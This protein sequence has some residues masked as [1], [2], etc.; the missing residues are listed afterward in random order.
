MHNESN[1]GRG[2]HAVTHDDRQRRRRA[3]AAFIER[4]WHTLLLGPKRLPLRNCDQCRQHNHDEP[5]PRYV[6]HSG[7]ID[8]PHPLGTCH[9]YQAA[10]L[11]LDHVLGLLDRHPEANLG[12]ATEP[13]G[14]VVVDVD[15]NRRGEPVPE[16]YARI[17]GVFDGWDVWALVLQRYRAAWQDTMTVGT[18]SGGMHLWYRLPAGATVLS[19]AGA[20]GWLIDIKS[21]RAYITAPGTRTPAGEYRRFGERMSPAQAPDWLMHHLRITGHIPEPKPKKTFFYKPQ[22]GGD[23][24]AQER[25]GRIADT[26]VHAPQGTGHAALCTATTAAAH[27]VA[28]G[29]VDELEAREVIRDAARDRNR[30]EAEIAHAWRSALS[31]AGG[32]R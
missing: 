2:S 26:L 9:G 16:K 7:V 14:L 15:T 25:L 20:F 32:C 29:R 19:K 30:T 28:N 18:P 23:R 1:N 5:N 24:A 21:A 27:L 6:P 17:D 22:Y 11:D 31:K 3:A 12:V 8:C 13:S 4:G 10:S